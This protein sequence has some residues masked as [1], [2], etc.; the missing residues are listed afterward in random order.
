MILKDLVQ[1]PLLVEYRSD[2]VF[3]IGQLGIY[4]YPL[5]F[6]DVIGQKVRENFSLSTQT[7][8]NHEILSHHTRGVVDSGLDLLH[9]LSFYFSIYLN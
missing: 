7:S 3:I 6:F 5:F 1:S 9:L 8:L 4:G 2:S